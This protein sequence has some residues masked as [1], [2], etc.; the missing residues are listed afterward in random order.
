M[1]TRRNFFKKL[2]GSFILVLSFKNLIARSRMNSKF[3]KKVNRPA[4]EMIPGD[5]IA[6]VSRGPFAFIPISPVF[7]WHSF[8]LPMGTDALISEEIC[9]IMTE[10][11][12]GIW[13]RP[14][15]LGLDS[16]R[17]LEEKKMWGLDSEED[18]FGMRFPKLPLKSEYCNLDEMKKIVKNRVNILKGIGIRHIFLLNHHGG[19]GQFDT[20]KELANELS[21][22]S[23][24]V[25]GLKTYQFNDLTEADGWFGYGGH[26]GYSETT[27]VLAFR[28]E[29]VNLKK[30]PEGE[31][32]VS[33]YGILHN[34]PIIEEKWNPNNTNISIAQKL[35][36]RVI[37]NFINYI[38][39]VGSIKK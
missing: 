17:S 32:F 39:G 35:R 14:L 34:K 7:E 9:K 21:D 12:G 4:E 2:F 26:A 20:I 25:H 1:N 19:K 16:F 15:S 5:I 11:V 13:F 29:L 22:T 36:N 24:T 31:L 27:W 6:S 3:L 30:I 8:H 38:K 33:E 37:K 28:P 10:E 23:V 18:V